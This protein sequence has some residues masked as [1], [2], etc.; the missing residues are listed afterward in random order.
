MFGLW[1]WKYRMTEFH[2]LQ[3][4]KVFLR[5]SS[6]STRTH[7][8]SWA[9]QICACKIMRQN[10]LRVLKFWSHLLCASAMRSWQSVCSQ[11]KSHAVTA[12]KVVRRWMK[13]GQ[14]RS[15]EGWHRHVEHLQELRR[16]GRR[17]VL[18]WKLL[19]LSAAMT[20]WSIAYERQRRR[21]ESR[22]FSERRSLKNSIWVWKKLLQLNGINSHNDKLATIL[23]GHIDRLFANRHLCAW[24][25]FVLD[26]RTAHCFEKMLNVSFRK[27][28][29]NWQRENAKVSL[30]HWNLQSIISR[31]LRN[32]ALSLPFVFWSSFTWKC[33][34]LLRLD[35]RSRLARQTLGF[36]FDSLIIN[37]LLKKSLF[38]NLG[39]KVLQRRSAHAL[40]LLSFADWVKEYQDT[41]DKVCF[42]GKDLERWL[43]SRVLNEWRVKSVR[44]RDLRESAS[45]IAQQW[46]REIN[47]KKQISTG[48]D[49]SI[50]SA[51]TSQSPSSTGNSPLIRAERVMWKDVPIISP[52]E[53]STDKLDVLSESQWLEDSIHSMRFLSPRGAFA[54][55]KSLTRS[56][57]DELRPM[58]K[59]LF[60]PVSDSRNEQAT[61]R[62]LRISMPVPVLPRRPTQEP[63]RKGGASS[64]DSRAPPQQEVAGVGMRIQDDFPHRV[65][66]LVPGGPADRSGCIEPGDILVAVDQSDVSRLSSSRIR[67]LIAGSNGSEVRL[68]LKKAQP[69]SSE[70]VEVVLQREFAVRSSL[71]ILANEKSRADL[72]QIF[73][74]ADAQGTGRLSITRTVKIL[75]QMGSARSEEELESLLREKLGESI[76]DCDHAMFL[77]IFGF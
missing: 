56:G 28:E 71:G 58:S 51:S 52:E 30:S 12:G 61:S 6:F 40:L 5:W 32:K 60:A 41:A 48:M 39:V 64:E 42:K 1:L 43:L 76:Q 47:L 16:R 72:L 21:W 4:A 25:M 9:M 73:R 46:E 26:C 20:S 10:A 53:R 11:R 35:A 66:S 27:I 31:Q 13:L 19:D 75:K 65:I 67:S 22:R 54:R 29:W 77:T 17:V 23:L 18:R 45:T 55:W 57:S 74:K 70:F 68:V 2:G 34:R 49:I 7:F 50:R 24:K 3:G 14:A 62:D 37:S 36:Y 33:R 15:F 44:Q 59:D 38:R 8:K 69:S 63:Q